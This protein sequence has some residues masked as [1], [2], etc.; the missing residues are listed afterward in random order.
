[1]EA[2]PYTN[3]DTA[4]SEINRCQK[5]Y[6]NALQAVTEVIDLW[7]DVAP[8]TLK[9][10]IVFDSQGAEGALVSGVIYGQPFKIN[11]VPH[12]RDEAVVAKCIVSAVDHAGD[13]QIRVIFLY[14]RDGD[15]LSEDGQVVVSRDASYPGYLWL[16]NLIGAFIRTF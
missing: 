5:Q 1:M 6:A 14:A 12:V 8:K 3:A 10:A 15:V 16:C 13:M 2:F 4:N 7:R 9:S 11:V